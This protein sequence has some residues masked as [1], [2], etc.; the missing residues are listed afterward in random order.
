M[1]FPE[2]SLMHMSEAA[3]LERFP[4]FER[5]A[6]IPVLKDM[7]DHWEFTYLLPRGT[8]GGVPIVII[9]KDSRTITKVYRTQ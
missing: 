8:L 7:E 3:I 9:A 1:D 2:P 6:K 5:G 4:G